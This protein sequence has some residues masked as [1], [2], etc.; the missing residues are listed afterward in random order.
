MRTLCLPLMSAALTLFWLSA[1]LAQPQGKPPFPPGPPPPQGP[2]PTLMLLTE[3]SV[4]TDLKLTA[5]QIKKVS[6]AINKLQT[7]MKSTF[8]VAPDQREQKMKDIMKTA[9][10]AAD[11]ILTTE[12]KQRIK[13]ISLQL[14]GSQ[15]FANADVVKDLS[16]TE[17]QQAKIKTINDGIG[18]QMGDLFQGKKLPPQTMHKKVTDIKK[19]ADADARKLLTSEQ[20]SMWNEMTGMPFRG[21]IRMMPP[22]GFGPPPGF[23]PP[24]F[25][26]Q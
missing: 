24:G 16:L 1:A 9:D 6:A 21:E 22:M 7:A 3:K 23:G 2:P 4:Q 12:Q 26:K 19:S 5:A 25:P 15:A 20:A 8:N 18:K 10:Q 17:E 14:Q 13:Q 11:E